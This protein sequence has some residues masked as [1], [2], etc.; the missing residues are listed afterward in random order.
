MNILKHLFIFITLLFVSSGL[1][2]G[3]F[4]IPVEVPE[5]E[6][7]NDYL[8]R[9][10][11]ENLSARFITQ[12]TPLSDRNLFP[13]SMIFGKTKPDRFELSTFLI[14]AEDFR[15]S[16]YARG[17]GSESI[18]G[19]FLAQPNNKLSF[20]VSF[21][22][23]ERLAQDPEYKGKKWRGLAGEVESAMAVYKDRGFQIVAGRFGS[24]WGPS[25][26]SLIL[27]ETARPMDG[28]QFRG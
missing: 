23:D 14:L 21:L 8:Q 25:R 28:I 11:F 9:D 1:Q 4:L 5:Y 10:E 27:S 12:L 22:L 19:G 20:Y 18:R 3:D 15:S 17:S 7:L 6:I 2:A 24:S 26:Q 16:K 13:N